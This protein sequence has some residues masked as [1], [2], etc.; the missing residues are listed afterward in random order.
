MD[1][2]DAVQLMERHAAAWNEHDVDGLIELLT[3]D[4]IYDAAVGRHAYG[5]RHVGHK[6]LRD[7]FAT[8]F[9]S[10]PDA[11]W[12]NPAHSACGDHGFSIWTFRATK[13]DGQKVEVRGIDLLRFRGGRICHKDTFRKQVISP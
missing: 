8:I 1:S 2:K 4:C 10:F 12:D 11:R 5:E 6:A 9:Q 3:I 13:A 7:A